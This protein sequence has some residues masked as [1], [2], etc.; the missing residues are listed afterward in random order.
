MALVPRGMSARCAHGYGVWV[1]RIYNRCQQ[2]PVTI[3]HSFMPAKRAV[4]AA[5]QRSTQRSTAAP[6]G[7]SLNLR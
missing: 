4:N 1:A 2:R 7:S 3:C 6:A 5:G